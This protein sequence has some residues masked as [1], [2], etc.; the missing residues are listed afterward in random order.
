[1]WK[2]LKAVMGTPR[3]G[4]DYSYHFVN[5]NLTIINKKDIAN[6]SN[7]DFTNIGPELSKDIMVPTNASIYK[8]WGCT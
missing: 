5:T 8:Y 4:N 2:V 7:N 1:M 3:L 6:I